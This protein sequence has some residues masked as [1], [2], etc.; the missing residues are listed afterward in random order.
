MQ[1]KEIEVFSDCHDLLGESPRWHPNE[2]RLYWVDIEAGT[3][4][5]QSAKEKTPITHMVNLKIGCLAFESTGSLLLA[6]SKGI[7]RWNADRSV[8]TLLA[9]PEAGKA[10]ARF[11]DGLVDAVGRFW[12]GT[13]TENDA[14]STLYCLEADLHLRSM[15]TGV[16]ISNGIGW[17]TENNLMYFTDTMK[18]IIWQYDFD[19]ETGTLANQRTYLEF[20]GE[21]VPDGLAVDTDGNLWIVICN[22]GRIQV[23]DPSGKQLDQLGFPTRCIT[24]CTFGGPELSDLFV[25]SSRSLLRPGE[26]SRDTQAGH[27]FRL[28]TCSH[29][30]PDRFFG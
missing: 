16:T 15:V 23:H 4:H 9:D 12:A 30:Q 22:G 13:M 27:V 5:S 11:N 25:T 10:D 17:N 29:G 26:Q 18:R 8:L 2:N 6:T 21:G 19:L 7:Q 14:S 24:A 1:M 20:T 28:A 3:I